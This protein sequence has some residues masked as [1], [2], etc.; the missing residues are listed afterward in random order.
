MSLQKR[1]NSSFHTIPKYSIDRQDNERYFARITI[2][3]AFYHTGFDWVKNLVEDFYTPNF[4]DFEKK[5]NVNIVVVDDETTLLVKEAEYDPVTNLYTLYI[6]RKVGEK[7]EKNDRSIV[8][9]LIDEITDCLVHEDT[10]RQQNQTSSEKDPYKKKDEDNPDE[11]YM[12]TRETSAY[13]RQIA[14]QYRKKKYDVKTTVRNLIKCTSESLSPLES[15][16]KSDAERYK[17]IG[18]KVWRKFL[19]EVYMYFQEI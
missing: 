16:S 18:G 10:H 3:E 6:P 8:L 19:E 12:Q 13:A 2:R 14:E 4:D 11:Y 5:Y 7:V 9:R 17:Q 1:M 15:S